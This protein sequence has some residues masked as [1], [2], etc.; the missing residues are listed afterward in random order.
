MQESA[1]RVKV[2]LAWDSEVTETAD[3]PPQPITSSLTV[4]LDLVVADAKNR[5]KAASHSFDNSYEIAEFAAAPGQTYKVF[6]RRP[7]GTVPVQY[8]I[9]WT[10]ETIT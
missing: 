7:S 10:V 9:A 3:N 5:R 6:I 4:D 2:A 1:T 8:G